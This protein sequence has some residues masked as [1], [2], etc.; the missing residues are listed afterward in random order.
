MSSLPVIVAVTGASGA[1][2]AQRLFQFFA[3][4]GVSAHVVASSAGRLVYH[5]ETGRNLEEDLPDGVPLYGEE[6]FSAPIASGSFR[7]QG[8]VIVP[9]T[10]GT[11]AA[12]ANG[13]ANNLIHRAADVCL[14]ERRPLIVVPRETPLSLVHLKNMMAIT[15]AG[16]LV[17]PPAPGFY[18]HPQSVKDL[19]DFIVARILDHLGVPQ[20][21][22]PAWQGL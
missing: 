20:D 6:D 9:C 5:L 22:V 12:I 15:E 18:H 1:P 19:L 10:M 14:K 13:L 17:L 21:L 4:R 2:Y 3:Q 7:T 16:G 8:M 11:L